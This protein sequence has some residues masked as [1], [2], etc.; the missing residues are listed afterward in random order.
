MVSGKTATVRDVLKHVD[1]NEYDY[2][3]IEIN[4]MQLSDPK[5]LYS[6]IYRVGTRSTTVPT[7]VDKN[8]R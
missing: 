3:I 1:S 8:A 2:Q 6:L 5:Q 7:Q 4:G